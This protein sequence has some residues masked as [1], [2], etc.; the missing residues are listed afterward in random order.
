MTDRD[1]L[2][3]TP[4]GADR[5]VH[6]GGHTPNFVDFRFPKGAGPF[7]V[8]LVIHG[9]FWLSAYDLAHMGHLCAAF[10][11][12][13][14]ITCNLEYRRIGDLGGGWPGTFQDVATGTDY[15]F[16]RMSADPRFDPERT[17][18]LGF[19]AGGHLALWLSSR[20]RACERSPLFSR[21]KDFFRGVV[22]LAGVT[23]LRAAWKLRLGD[24][25]VKRLMGGTPEE[26]PERYDAGSPIELLPT[27][28]KQVLIHGADDETVP[29]SQ[30][31]AFVERARSVGDEPLLLKLENTGHFELVDPE[32]SA[33]PTVSRA[34]LQLLGLE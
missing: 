2:T 17:A 20:H 25:A 31:E 33:W 4:P 27:G 26:A 6:Y 11:S 24:G 22:S 23:D 16:E 15:V 28:V 7:P 21:P 12:K 30:S 8:L 13:G 29:V 1:I 10:T 14:V 18:A 19:S 3:R 32:S 5:R 34:T 9:G